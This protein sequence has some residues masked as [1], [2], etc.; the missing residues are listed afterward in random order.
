MDITLHRKLDQQRDLLRRLEAE[1]DELVLLKGK[2]ESTL[3]SV[4]VSGVRARLA[5]PISERT[6]TFLESFVVVAARQELDAVRS[7]L[8]QEGAHR[9]T[10]DLSAN[11]SVE[12]VSIDQG[13]PIEFTLI[14]APG[15]GL[16]DMADVLSFIQKEAKP[17]TVILVGMMAGIPG[18]SRLLDVQAPRN[19]INGTRL[20]TRGGRIV[21]EPQGRD[22]DPILHHRLQSLD[23]TNRKIAD[24]PLVTHKRTVCVAAKLD[25]VSKMSENCGFFGT[26]S[27][28]PPDWR[29]PNH[30]TDSS[31]V[32]HRNSTA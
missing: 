25:E 3:R 6:G 5:K 1:H 22:V 4:L 9:E 29:D 27:H 21:P 23:R 16:G 12:R 20:G 31:K 15:Q 30:R 26:S 19:I 17:K 10:S 13:T 18:K 2:H 11:W 14:L 8:D 7:Y 28:R 32:R 24:I